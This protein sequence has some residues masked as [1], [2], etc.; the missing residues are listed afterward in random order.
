[1]EHMHSLLKTY[2]YEPEYYVDVTGNDY[3]LTTWKQEVAN[4]RGRTA[5]I[6]PPVLAFH[7]GRL[8]RIVRE[9]LATHY[10]LL[11][12]VYIPGGTM[13]EHAE[14]VYIVIA[15]VRS[16][17]QQPDAS[18]PIIRASDTTSVHVSMRDFQYWGYNFSFNCYY[19]KDVTAQRTA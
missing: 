6:I 5:F 4:L 8:Y 13:A 18:V 7:P 3:P 14:S 15:D 11:G 12:I 9:H 2:G 1:M 17:S 16:P 19:H 10:C